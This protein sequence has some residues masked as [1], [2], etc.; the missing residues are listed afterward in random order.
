[1]KG[2]IGAAFAAAFA[3][4]LPGIGFAAD[5]SAEG[6]KRFIHEAVQGN[7]GEIQLGQLADKSAASNQ[8]REFG[9]TL[10]TDHQNAN[11]KVL[12][13]AKSMNV[14]GADRAEHRGA[15][16]V[17]EALEDVRQRV[18]F[19]LRR[20]HGQGS[21]EGYR[22]IQ[23][24]SE[25]RLGTRGR[26]LRPRDASDPAEALRTFARRLQNETAK[27]ARAGSR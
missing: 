15:R 2:L 27:T 12:A 25:R 5:Q 1:M 19:G 22:H 17:Q 26:G 13:I 23:Q 3:L 7:L 10:A 11:D 8:V 18:R 9:R 6:A 21:Q 14:H 16:G 4:T 20:L 24:G